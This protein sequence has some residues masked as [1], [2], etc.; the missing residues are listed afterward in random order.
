MLKN[1]DK[2]KSL[3]NSLWG[4]LILLNVDS[5][6]IL[7]QVSYLLFIKS[8]DN[9]EI[10]DEKNFVKTGDRYISKYFD[11][12]YLAYPV[13]INNFL[14]ATSVARTPFIRKLL[15][16]KRVQKSKQE[17]RWSNFIKIT[18]D[19]ELLD[20]IELNVF[21]FINK[22][23][24]K[25]LIHQNLISTANL[26]IKQPD[27]LRKIIVKIEEI[28]VEMYKDAKEQGCSFIEM[29]GSMY[30][31][32]LEQKSQV[33]KNGLIFTPKHIVRLMIELLKPKL[34]DK[35]IDPVCGTAN[36]LALSYQYILMNQNQSKNNMNI[37]DYDGFNI[38]NST[39][40]IYV[41]NL[42]ETNLY[43]FDI[44]HTMAY[45]GFMNLMMHGVNKPHVEQADTLSKKCK[46]EGKYDIVFAN[47]PF[48]AE[49]YQNDLSP[50]LR[51]KTNSPEL[52]FLD[53]ISSMLRNEGKAAVIVSEG[54]LFGSSK[55]H[56]HAKEIL[57]K[58]NSVEAIISLPKGVFNPYTGIK[59]SIIIFK[60]IKQNSAIWNTEKVWFYE[61]L[62]DGYSLDK[63]RR[64]LKDFP[65][66]D[67][68]NS[69]I[70]RK[71]SYKGDS[72]NQFF[73]TLDKI[74]DND[75]DLSYRRYRKYEYKE[76]I[77]ESPRKILA[78][79]D[80]LEL[81]IKVAI[82]ELNKLIL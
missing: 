52:L 55:A 51:I 21:P 13:G 34:G 36:F 44:N 62:S 40:D 48:Q 50:S 49:I 1:N 15:N 63:Q 76:E 69:F 46:I 20:H 31:L 58:D 67:L 61:L 5:M 78:S 77:Y 2:L 14:T 18:S 10:E 47:P 25:A 38:L 70:T 33:S 3:I 41:K 6:R 26:H 43:G 30:E 19:Q 53:R 27:L 73:V 79:L 16:K 75:F 17:L 4:T 28:F 32:L 72:E 60:K 81:E 57:L 65:L 74:I 35:V 24:D 45:L 11:G 23:G 54:I 8:I 82:D 22:I 68:I 9:N 42:F 80:K 29:Q 66:P 64:R 59:T 39:N 71:K 7:E 12:K 56:K 37:K